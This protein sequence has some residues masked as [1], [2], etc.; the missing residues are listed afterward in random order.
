MAQKK[1]SHNKPGTR[2]HFV[3]DKVARGVIRLMLLLPYRW[4]VPAMGWLMSRVIG[5]IAP[6]HS[7]ARKHLAMIYTDATEAEIA[8]MATACLNNAGRS[9]IENYST[10]EF[11]ARMRDTPMEGPGFEALKEAATQGR[12]VILQSG[13]FGN[14]EAARAVMYA[15]GIEPGGIYR[16]MRNPYFHEHYVQTLLAYGGPC[17]ERGLPG[18]RGVMN[19]LKSGGQLI[20]LNDQHDMNAPVLQFMGRP[21]RTTLSPAELA[22]RFNALVIPYFAIRQPDGLT[23]RC[24]ME[25][26]IPHTDA[27]TMTQE[28][29]DRLAARIRANPEQ[30]FW[31]PRRWRV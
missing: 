18:M 2:A 29:N 16:V 22:L 26:P 31:V 28:M 30:W 8:R 6:Y 12:A 19:H 4:R 24:I 11:L 1:T 21:A 3:T 7:A 20:I 9:L 15:N 14:Y 17:F 5:R 23:F 10:Q 13:H 25:A 27:E